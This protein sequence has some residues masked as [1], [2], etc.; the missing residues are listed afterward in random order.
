MTT[1]VACIQVN[2]F[3]KSA[4]YIL[5]EYEGLNSDIVKVKRRLGTVDIKP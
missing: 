3:S 4:L 1:A 2:I 5:M